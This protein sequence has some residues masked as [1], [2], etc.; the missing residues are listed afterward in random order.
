MHLGKKTKPCEYLATFANALLSRWMRAEL[1]LESFDILLLIS[2]AKLEQEY[3]SQKMFRFQVI[4]FICT[5]L[6]ILLGTR[7]NYFL[8]S[9]WN[10]LKHLFLLAHI[11]IIQNGKSCF[12]P[13]Y[14]QKRIYTHCKKKK[15][16]EKLKEERKKGVKRTTAERVLL[17]ICGEHLSRLL[18]LSFQQI[19]NF[20]QMRLCHTHCSI[21]CFSFYRDTRRDHI[22]SSMCVAI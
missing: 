1:H 21:T 9:F 12:S 8:C 2:L 15:C 18:T 13:P 5:D 20:V 3:A 22:L 4:M 11:K 7:R 6:G 17:L 10:F 14:L 19:Q 16:I